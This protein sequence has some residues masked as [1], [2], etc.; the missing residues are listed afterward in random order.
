MHVMNISLSGYVLT[1]SILI[2]FCTK[3]KQNN[4]ILSATSKKYLASW[5]LRFRPVRERVRN[6]NICRQLTQ[7]W[8]QVPSSPTVDRGGRWVL[9]TTTGLENRVQNSNTFSARG[10]ECCLWIMERRN[11]CFIS[12]ISKTKSVH[13]IKY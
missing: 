2:L 3:I 11:V 8:S 7:I 9:E 13:Y 5:N 1:L 12:L 4:V 6:P 10:R